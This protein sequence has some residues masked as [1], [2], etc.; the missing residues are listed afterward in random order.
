M[1]FFQ[2]QPIQKRLKNATTFKNG[3]IVQIYST[4]QLTWV[5]GE[6]I[7]AQGDHAV[8]VR[9]K[10]TNKFVN[11]FDDSKCRIIEVRGH[12]FIKKFFS[13]LTRTYG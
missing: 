1:Y 7:G 4:S 5:L 10:G 9:Y 8:N 12:F 13:I 3:T 6:I 11:P 2:A